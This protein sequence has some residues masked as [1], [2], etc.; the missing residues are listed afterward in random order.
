MVVGSQAQTQ[1]EPQKPTAQGIDSS[2]EEAAKPQESKPS[3]EVESVPV[4]VARQRLDLSEQREAI[5]ARY[6]QQQ[7]ACWQ[8]FAVNDCLIEARRIRRQAL[9]PIRQQELVL[10]AQERAWRT[11]ERE[12]RLLDKQPAP[13]H[14]P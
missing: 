3:Q 4:A 12:Q 11:S 13:E 2:A 6:A 7:V 9:Q 1:P 14:K 8:K 10:N 5:M